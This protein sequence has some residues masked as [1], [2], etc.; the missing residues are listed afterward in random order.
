MQYKDFGKTGKK[1]S[2]L[3]F[4]AMR[5]PMVRVGDE[6]HVDEEQ[7]IAIIHRAFEA[8]VNYLDT[9]VMYCGGESQPVCGKALKGWRDKVSIA[10]K[11]PLDRVNTVDDYWKILEDSLKKLD[12]DTIDFYHFHG[13]GWDAYN[14]K[15]LPLGLDKAMQSAKEQGM[16]NHISFSFHDKPENMIKLVDTGLFESI[17]CQYNIFDQANAA[18][19]AYAH[20]KGLGI[21][22]MGPVGGGRLSYNSSKLSAAMDRAVTGTPEIALR[23]CMSNPNI[24]CVLSGMGN[25][26]MVEQNIAVASAEDN[27]L[28]A[29]ELEQIAAITN[30]VKELLY[31]TGCN[32]CQ[33]CPAD[34]KIPFILAQYNNIKVYDMEELARKQLALVGTHPWHGKSIDECTDCGAC[35]SACPQKIKIRDMMKETFAL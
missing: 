29:K 3:G 34:I 28:S 11:I 7:A 22:N 25:M 15:V 1:V 19:I 12:V 32:Y 14:N 9:A 6:E 21:V 5:L 16:I 26:D 4:G 10:T 24:D 27:T 35:E 31:C 17:L 8:G 18:S 33:P 30:Q 13:I 20:E 2:R 23:F